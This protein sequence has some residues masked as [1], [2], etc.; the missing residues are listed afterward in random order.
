M[1]KLTV[2]SQFHVR[3]KIE[4]P[5]Y[6]HTLL[7]FSCRTESGGSVLK[8]LSFKRDGKTLVTGDYQQN[9]L[10]YRIHNPERNDSGSY[11]CKAT[12]FD[13]DRAAMIKSAGTLIVSSKLQSCVQ[14]SSL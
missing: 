8:Q 5:L 9:S 14:N 4:P 6:V 3:T 11:I 2:A 1:Y 13:S 12:F 10:L 7:L